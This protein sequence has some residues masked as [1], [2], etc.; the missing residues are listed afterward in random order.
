MRWFSCGRLFSATRASPA[1]TVSDGRLQGE[2]SLQSGFSAIRERSE[3]AAPGAVV[4]AFLDWPGG[5]IERYRALPVQERRDYWR[6]YSSEAISN[7]V[8]LAFHL[9]GELGQPHAASLG[10]LETFAELGSFYRSVKR[11]AWCCPVCSHT[12]R[13]CSRIDAPGRE[14]AQPGISSL[15][16]ALANS[17]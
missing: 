10:V 11:S 7:G 1:L 12:W 6:M 9:H 5:T 4:S 15:R 13:S 17:Q 14:S 2:V 8:F 3:L 16:C